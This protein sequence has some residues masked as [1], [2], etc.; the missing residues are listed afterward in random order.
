MAQPGAGEGQHGAA[1]VDAQPGAHAGR[2]QLQH[3]PGAG[4]DVQQ[5]AQLRAGQQGQQCGLHI[6]GGQAERPHLVPIGAL[7]AEGVGGDAR[8][9][10]QDAGGAAAV[11]GQHGIV[12]RQAGEQVQHG[13]G[14]GQGV[15]GEGEPDVRALP[16]PVQQA[17]VAQ[18]L[19]VAGQAWLALAED[20][21]ELH[22][23]ERAA[24]GERK[25]SQPGGF[26]AGAQ[27]GEERLHGLRIT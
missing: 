16:D 13:C 11:G 25:Q 10:R 8:P 7:A 21:G 27:G 18:Q 26:G 14:A 15:G 4:A 12:L 3:A 5:P 9:L 22:D 6:G 24:G 2:Q 23:A 1:G 20:L 17:G 19:E